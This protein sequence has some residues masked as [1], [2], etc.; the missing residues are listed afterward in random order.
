MPVDARTLLSILVLP[1]ETKKGCPTI[2]FFGNYWRRALVPVRLKLFP[3]LASP[4]SPPYLSP[5]T[6][7]LLP[8][9]FS[10]LISQLLPMQVAMARRGAASG[11]RPPPRRRHAR[12]GLRH[13]WLAHPPAVAW[14]AAGQARQADGRR[15][16]R[17]TLW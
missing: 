5:T 3:T 12:R 17:P 13:A 2:I 6:G 1:T 10:Y 14:S 8:S 15:R 7:Q 11:A 16:G 4:L 9:H